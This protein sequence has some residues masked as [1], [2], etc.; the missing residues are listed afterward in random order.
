MSA[1]TEQYGAAE[2]AP[3]ADPAAERAEVL[4]HFLTMLSA[5]TGDGSAKRQTG[6]KPSW[7]VD[8]SHEPAMFSH[9]NKWKHGELR[10][11]DSGAHPLVHLAW[12]ALAIAYQEMAADA[13]ATDASLEPRLMRGSEADG[14]T[15]LWEPVCYKLGCVPA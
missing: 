14:R 7:K 2:Y 1:S 4:G 8:P 3:P 12:R 15:H 11:P 9:L 5:A 13:A 10:D 6:E